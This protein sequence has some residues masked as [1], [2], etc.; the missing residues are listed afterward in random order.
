MHEQPGQALLK[1]K[2]LRDLTPQC[3]FF[4]QEKH[5]IM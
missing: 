2:S 3:A 1:R 5:H 4:Q